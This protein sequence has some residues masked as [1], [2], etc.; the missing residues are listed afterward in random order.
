[1]E[2]ILITG[3]THGLGVRVAKMLESSF[4]VVLSASEN[5]PEFM[6]HKIIS[7]P[8]GV[9]PTFAHEMLKLAL[10]KGCSYILP[11]LLLEIESLSESLVL[12]EEYGIT[13]LCP[14]KA[15]LEDMEIV[16]NPPKELPLSVL[17]NKRDLLTQREVDIEANGLGIISD[18]G[19]E[20]LLA[21]AR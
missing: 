15:Q 20:F 9:N 18:S 19:E 2:K 16:P 12:F 14:S 1:M 7:I 6:S 17:V 11:L 21:I 10:D 5:I 3:A 8:K 13:V 4:E